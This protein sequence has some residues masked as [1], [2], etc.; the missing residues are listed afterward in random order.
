MTHIPQISERNLLYGKL[1][2]SLKDMINWED[3]HPL[4]NSFLSLEVHRIHNFRFDSKSIY[5]NKKRKIVCALIGQIFNLNEIKYRYR[6][7]IDLDVEI[8]EYLFSLINLDIVYELKGFYILFIFDEKRGKGFIFS[9]EFGAPL[10]LYFASTEEAFLFSTSLKTIIKQLKETRELDFQAVRDFIYFERLIPNERTLVKGVYKITPHSYIEVDSSRKVFKV[11]NY[12]SPKHDKISKKTA[13]DNLLKS[14]DTHLDTMLGNLNRSLTYLTLTGGWDSNLLLHFLNKSGR[15]GVRT[16]TI[17]GG[18]PAASEIPQVKALLNYYGAVEHFTGRVHEDTSC[19]LVNLVWIYEGYLFEGGIFLRYELARLLNSLA[20]SCVVLGSGCDQ[21]LTS[22][23]R[24]FHQRALKLAREYRNR[25]HKKEPDFRK[26]FRDDS[27]VKY[28]IRI[29]FNLKMHEILLNHFGVQ[30]IYPFVNPETI[31]CAGPLKKLN[32]RKK[33]YKELVKEEIDPRVVQSLCKS[34][35]VSDI[36]AL[37]KYNK[38]CLMRVL[39]T[40]FIRDVLTGSQI[41]TIKSSPETFALII[42]QLT[43][44][45]LFYRLFITGDFDNSLEDHL[46]EA[47]VDSF[48]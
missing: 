11:K 31:Q 36:V 27:P 3:N 34:G 38:D 21:V 4:F 18:S 32:F 24:P 26:E 7:N 47:E 17:D 29:D 23:Y 13:R 44:I 25:A 20:A 10:P 42:Y 15:V 14:I 30:G 46:L 9:S 48:F 8:V 5:V 1:N 43:Y 12:H 39:D 41:K 33:L 28:D 37:F 45:Y 40:S 22:D 6:I 2:W 16:V 19:N 35:A